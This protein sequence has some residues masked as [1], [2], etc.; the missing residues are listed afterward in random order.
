MTSGLGTTNQVSLAS[1]APSEK[2]PWLTPLRI[3]LVA[4]VLLC[5]LQLF[6]RLGAAFSQAELQATAAQAL[7]EQQP[8][9]P[10]TGDTS[11]AQLPGLAAALKPL[12]AVLAVSRCLGPLCDVAY[13]KPGVEPCTGSSSLQALCVAV[14]FK[15]RPGETLKISYALQPALMA[16]L[17]DMAIIVG[18]SG[19]VLFLL[20]RHAQQDEGEA[21]PAQQ[22]KPGVIET[23]AL[24]GVLTRVAFETALK[25]HN[26]SAPAVKVSDTDGCL[27]YFDLDRF[28]IINDTHGHIAGD[29]V[30]KTVAKRLKYTLGSDVLIGRLGGDE[31][32]VLLVDVASTAN[33]EQMGRV[34]IEQVSKPIPL[35]AISDS[36]GLS[37]GAYMLTR[38][39]FTVGEMLH[40]ADL[41]MY[42]AKRAGRG[43]LVFFDESMDESAR[44]RAQ[45]LAEL[46]RAIH[47]KQF[48]LAYQPQVDA[49]DSVRG[50]EALVRWKH[51][52]RGMVP[53]E[54]FIPVAE[55]SGLIVLLGKM[56]VDMVCAELV[57]L[58]SQNLALPYVSLNVSLK[59]LADKA[60]IDDVQE[61]LQRHALTASDLEFEITESTAM[62]GRGGKENITL[63][64]LSELGFRIAIDDFGT[65]YSSL[66]RLLDLKVDKLKIDKVFVSSIGKPRF[67]PALLELMIS[68]AQRLGI[69]SVAEGVETLDQVVWLRQ[70]GCQ[71]MQGYFYAKPMN[72][73]QLINWLKLQEGDDGF[74][75]GVWAPTEAVEA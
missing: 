49:F 64:K 12:D 26:E 71:M 31:F 29:Q 21:T 54:E 74:D 24:T 19:A 14:P 40:R 55:Q 73:A 33:I 34:L 45:I 69:K 7:I 11:K 10:I 63:N 42:E 61:A 44:S 16:A 65:G 36:V 37:I 18:L 59:Q 56:V 15:D 38:G 20:W 35:D 50:V 9:P 2:G 39:E 47:D 23:D 32:A 48:F 72:L 17:S 13:A 60:F 30:L 53:P 70:A 3:G 27:L 58:R 1:K 4:M 6:L 68:L 8:L 43:R 22:Q 66:G 46:K 75:D 62:V 67:D 25:R 52:T 51:P 57:S 41:A 5:G 28:K